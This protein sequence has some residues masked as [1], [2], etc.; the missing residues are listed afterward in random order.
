MNENQHVGKVGN[1]HARIGNTHADKNVWP[2]CRRAPDVHT[3]VESTAICA[4]TF[5]CRESYE[6]L[7]T[8]GM[9]EYYQAKRLKL[10]HINQLD[11][12]VIYL[13]V[14]RNRTATVDGS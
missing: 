10:R 13:F 4:I 7:S 11:P 6:F 5:S 14:K 12:K 9:M 8:F 2:A 1:A 3:P